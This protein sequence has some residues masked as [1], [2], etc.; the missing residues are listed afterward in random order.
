MVLNVGGLPSLFLPEP[1][2]LSDRSNAPDGACPPSCVLCGCC[3][4]PAV[5]SLFGVQIAADLPARSFPPPV[6]AL[7]SVDPREILHVPKSSS[8]QDR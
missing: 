8:V 5:P 7:V 4:Q 1:C 6:P 2:G 3:A